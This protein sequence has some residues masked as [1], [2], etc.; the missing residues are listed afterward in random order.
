MGSIQN[1]KQVQAI[2]KQLTEELGRE[3]YSTELLAAINGTWKPKKED[4]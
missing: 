1:A 3:P 2:I 4:K